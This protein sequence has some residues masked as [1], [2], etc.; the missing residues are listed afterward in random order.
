MRLEIVD[1]GVPAEAGAFIGALLAGLLAPPGVPPSAEA[2]L[3]RTRL[4][5]YLPD[6]AS[7]VIMV[8][9]PVYVPGHVPSRSKFDTLNALDCVCA[10]MV[11][12]S[13]KLDQ[14]K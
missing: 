2:G 8:P 14:S 9:K 11:I 6:R 4:S 13:C 7:I 3:L 12:I 10:F 5:A 1:A